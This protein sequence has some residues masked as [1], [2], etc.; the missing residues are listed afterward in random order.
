MIDLSKKLNLIQGDCLEL[1]KEIPDKSID[2]ILTDPPYGI[3]INKMNFVKSGA[4]KVGGAYRNDYS[5]SSTDWDAQGLTKKQWK[6]I[7]RVSKNQVI[8]GANNFSDI[9]PK[10]QCWYVWDKRGNEK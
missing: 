8:F 6:E 2:L 7:Q 4:I 9:L 3:G 5:N 1:L 10:S